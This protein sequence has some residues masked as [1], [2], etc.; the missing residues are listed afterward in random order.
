MSNA[1]VGDLL[2]ARI[3]RAQSAA[4]R[5]EELAA[6][7]HAAIRPIA[8]AVQAVADTL[9]RAAPEEWV[10]SVA[11]LA[12][13]LGE[14]GLAAL[15]AEI[16]E[17]PRWLR[18]DDGGNP[19]RAIA[20]NAF[21]ALLA[22]AEADGPGALG[23]VVETIERHPFAASAFVTEMH[24]VLSY[25]L[26]V[27]TDRT[28]GRFLPEFIAVAAE[29]GVRG[30]DLY[31]HL[32]ARSVP[33]S[34][35][36]LAA[37]H[38]WEEKSTGVPCYGI[39]PC[40]PWV[41]T[42]S[43]PATPAGAPQAVGRGDTADPAASA[44]DGAEASPVSPSPENAGGT[45]DTSVLGEKPASGEKKDEGGQQKP[46]GPEAGCRVWYGGR[47]VA[48]SGRIYAVIDFMWAREWASFDA[49]KSGVNSEAGDDTV[50]TWTCRA[51]TA[52][53]L[54]SLPWKLVADGESRVV[55]KVPR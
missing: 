38:A 18:A 41:D 26:S 46:D 36:A 21:A 11:T 1:P 25:I 50:F 22:S 51:N 37:I 13:R 53:A 34:D 19:G 7:H 28:A 14:V 44:Q 16:R 20:G 29:L 12:R 24:A 23:T 55:R 10:A 5:V 45:A 33:L 6:E 40:P 17:C 30:S 8:E 27:Q 43:P 54:L 31:D 42:G 9:S 32:R 35:S 2:A 4:R 47:P 52:L 15:P 49:L 48:V 39:P 3:A